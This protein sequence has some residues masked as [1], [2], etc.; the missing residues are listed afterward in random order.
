MQVLVLSTWFPYPPDNGSKIR[1]H[2]L[3]QALSADHDVTLIAF[4]PH[5]TSDASLPKNVQVMD[6][7]VDPF[8]YVNLPSWMKYASPIPLAFWPSRAMRNTL[9]QITSQRRFDAV[10]A[11]QT[12][13]AYYAASIPN[14][15]RVIDVD[16]SFS[17][18][19]HQRFGHSRG[20]GTRLRTW[21]SWQKTH[22]YEQR[23]FRKF[24]TFAVVSSIEVDFIAAMIGKSGGHVEVIRNGVD[25]GQFKPGQYHTQP[26][27][28]IYNGALTYRA[29]YDAM[30]FFL[31]DIYPHLRR[32]LPAVSLTITGSTEGVDRSG[33]QLRRQCAFLRLRGGHSI[34][35]R[36]QRSLCCALA[37]RQRHAA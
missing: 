4:R 20:T 10:V 30:R 8:R 11:I 34:G 25:C 13:M 2:Y 14:I 32:L 19:M 22:R 24:Q 23:V 33:L 37:A 17:F 21:F 29:N 18:Q 16:T 26:N 35:R 27:T 6:V 7:P 15:P 1:A 31:S 5:N 36:R 3:I 28:L 9:Q 12:P